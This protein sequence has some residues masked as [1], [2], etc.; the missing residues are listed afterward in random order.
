M[1]EKLERVEKKYDEINSLV[2]QP[3]IAGD[4]ER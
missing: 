4:V 3:E 2:C 1:L